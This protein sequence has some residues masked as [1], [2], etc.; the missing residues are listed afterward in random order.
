MG[1]QIEESDLDYLSMTAGGPSFFETRGSRSYRW[2]DVLEWIKTAPEMPTLTRK[3]ATEYIRGL[4]YQIAEDGL[5][6]FAKHQRGPVYHLMGHHARYRRED[7]DK[8]VAD[9]RA[10]RTTKYFHAR[11]GLHREQGSFRRRDEMEKVTLNLRAGDF[12]RMRD[13]YGH[14]ASRIIRGL[15]SAHLASKGV[16]PDAAVDDVPEP[17]DL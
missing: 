11:Q 17:D 12:Q 13:L 10:G 15:I 2:D 8:W 1:V 16:G 5:R 6:A 4:G 3:Q 9:R 7:L 14:L